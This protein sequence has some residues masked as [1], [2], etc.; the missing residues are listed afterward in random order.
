MTDGRK[1][2]EHK[3]EPKPRGDEDVSDIKS[4]KLNPD[5]EGKVKGGLDRSGGEDLLTENVT[6]N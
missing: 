5:E 6:L 4:K 1:D 2:R 3:T